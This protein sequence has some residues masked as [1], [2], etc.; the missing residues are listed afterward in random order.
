MK[1]LL[2]LCCTL[3]LFSSHAQNKKAIVKINPLALIDE[4]SFA[5]IQAGIE[6][7]VG[8]R[9]SW[10]N[11][12]GIHFRKGYYESSDTSFVNP[13]GY[14]IKTELRYYFSRLLHG[15]PDNV[16]EGYYLG[17]N[18][19]FIRDIHNAELGYYFLNDSSKKMTD[20]LGVKKSVFC[21]SILLGKQKTIG[22]HWLLDYYTGLGIRYRNVSTVSQEY[23][24]ERDSLELPIDLT[25][26]GIRTRNDSKPGKSFTG[27]FS[28]GIRFCY[29]F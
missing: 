27:N 21:S 15:A 25:V 5:T 12:A 20:N 19:C 6:F 2:L 28:L 18:L 9:M 7:P 22:K 14:K 23:L 29:R 1:F 26:A 11:E 3:L 24:Y 13:G 16:M 8:A 10:Y 17:I 4:A